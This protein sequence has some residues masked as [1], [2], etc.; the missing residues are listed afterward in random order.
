MLIFLATQTKTS[1]FL[2]Y[3]DFFWQY[4]SVSVANYVEIYQIENMWQR[5]TNGTSVQ[6]RY[7]LLAGRPLELTCESSCA[8]VRHLTDFLLSEILCISRSKFLIFFRQLE[9]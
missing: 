2:E 5:S 9:N 8:S 3:F 7:F 1:L 6:P 4:R